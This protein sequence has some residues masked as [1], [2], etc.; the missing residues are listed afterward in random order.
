M[1]RAERTLDRLLKRGVEDTRASD[2]A[3]VAPCRRKLCERLSRHAA[4]VGVVVGAER[5]HEV[6]GIARAS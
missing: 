2:L 3:G 4:D 5:K 1:T 6:G